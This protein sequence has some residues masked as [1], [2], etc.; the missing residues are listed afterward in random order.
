MG[1]DNCI[2][3]CRA[4]KSKRLS[5]RTSI[6]T[7]TNSL[8]D[9]KPEFL[10]DGDCHAL[11]LISPYLSSKNATAACGG[12]LFCLTFHLCNLVR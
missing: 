1:W 5:N 8:K 11:L 6:I 3:T 2:S 9:L 12:I 10:H 4:T 7:K